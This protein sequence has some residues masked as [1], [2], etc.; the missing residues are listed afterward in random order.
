MGN[1]EKGGVL[2]KVKKGYRDFTWYLVLM[3]YIYINI[4]HI[5]K[6]LKKTARITLNSSASN[7]L[8]ISEMSLQKTIISIIIMIIS[9][10]NI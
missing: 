1:K 10:I 5:E 3:T 6:Y 7:I 9:Q 4:I 8:K 2:I